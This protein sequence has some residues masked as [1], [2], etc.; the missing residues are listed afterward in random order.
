MSSRAVKIIQNQGLQTLYPKLL[1]LFLVISLL[2]CQNH[3]KL[4]TAIPENA[5]ALLSSDHQPANLPFTHLHW[6]QIL[7]PLAKNQSGILYLGTDSKVL[8]STALKGIQQLPITQWQGIHFEH[9]RDAQGQ[10]WTFTQVKNLKFLSQEAALVEEAVRNFQQGNSAKWVQPLQ[11]NTLQLDYPALSRFYGL[12]EQETAPVESLRLQLKTSAEQQIG[13]AYLRNAI[14]WAQKDLAEVLSLVPASVRH[15]T[16]STQELP[17]PLHG[18]A[19]F[20]LHFGRGPQSQR[21]LVLAFAEANQAQTALQ[22][23][24]KTK[25]AL[26]TVDYQTYTLQPILDPGLPAWPSQQAT[27]ITQDRFLILTSSTQL[28]ERWIDAL[29]VGNT[30]AKQL[31]QVPQ[32]L[33]M[34]FS[35]DRGLGYV[36][37]QLQKDFSLDLKLPETLQWEGQL[38]GKHWDFTTDANLETTPSNAAELWQMDLPAGTA[39]Q[40]WSVEAWGQC[41]VESSENQLL[42]LDLEGN[43]GWSKKLEAPIVGN[44]N[45][46]D[47]PGLQQTILY[48]ATE[49]AI[50]ALTN[51]GAE[52][53]GYPLAL[54][55]ATTS[56]VSVGGR[57]QF[58]FY[59][60]ADGRIYGLDKRGEPL[61]GWNP[62]PKLGLVKQPLG[63]FQS[64][65]EDY[66][67][68]L[69]EEGQFHV[70][71]RATQ[72]HFP[73]QNFSGPFL[74]P[75]QWQ[76][77]RHSE[78]M[79]VAHAQGKAQVL[80]A[81]GE[82]FPLALGTGAAA[83]TRLCFVDLVGDGRKDYLAAQGTQVFLH[84]YLKDKYQLVFQKKFKGAIE[85]IGA[86]GDRILLG[87]P[88][89]HEVWALSTKGEVVTG[90]PVAGDGF[91]GF[92]KEKVVVTAVGG[93]V[94]G[95][96]W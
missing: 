70:L 86:V 40:L 51:K 9:F 79:V 71:D 7:L 63:F 3:Q 96:G 26:P 48:F 73:L 13:Q 30:V 11:A 67:L 43:I 1:G 53:P 69:N 81:Q 75:P 16:P 31:R 62:G 91:A 24:A 17:E 74:S 68:V 84:A 55:L 59:A 23:F 66:L 42:L 12:E 78:R 92:E 46:V 19:T 38:E 82:S 83:A 15:F 33:W 41:L 54:N 27:L 28:M 95:Y 65:S 6:Q 50:H 8:S 64:T 89:L 61:S 47:D 87:I 52:T 93:R 49:K 18:K 4:E 76:W 77:D 39:R 72:P 44:I 85:E 36:L 90:F 20:S 14:E 22:E 80:N 58:L 45:P 32:G 34:R 5:L 88:G 35:N 10:K 57:E 29:V 25:G 21:A 60:S 94:Y 37:N 2:G 56:G